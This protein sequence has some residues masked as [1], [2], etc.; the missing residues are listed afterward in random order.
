MQH[1]SVL[2]AGLVLF[3]LASSFKSNDWI[4]LLDKDLSQWEY[5]LSYR[6]KT[7][8]KGGDIKDKTGSNIS[9]IGYNKNVNKVF[10]V[11]EEDGEP[12]LRISG[13]IY[14]CVFTKNEFENYHL[15]LKVKWGT[16]KWVPRLDEY[17]DSG[18]LYHSQ[19][20][21]GVDY[22]KSWMLSQELQIIE[23]GMGDY[24]S[25]ATSQIDISAEKPMGKENHIF[26]KDSATVAFGGGSVN[27]NFCQ[28]SEDHEKPAGEWNTVEL[29]CYGDKSL[30]IVN[31]HVVMA[32]ENSR[33]VQGNETFPLTKGRIQLQSEAAEVFYKDIK[34]KNID[35]IPT[36]YASYFK[37]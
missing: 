33:Y 17:M 21:C 31:G 1:I 15:K 32:L 25:I 9:P 6:H 4:P 16:K 5:Y 7:D 27:G 20:E 22:W 8:Y 23:N 2:S 14:G 24:W 34:I 29:I 13:E 11:L 30:H 19:G 12:V 10:S 26:N 37:E 28:V 3:I 35:G 18:V 36:A